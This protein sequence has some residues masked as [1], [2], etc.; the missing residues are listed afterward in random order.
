[1][2]LFSARS[3]SYRSWAGRRGRILR[4]FS[5]ASVNLHSLKIRCVQI[6]ARPKLCCFPF[7]LCFLFCCLLVFGGPGGGFGGFPVGSKSSGKA[8]TATTKKKATKTNTKTTQNKKQTKMTKHHCLAWTLP[9][10]SLKRCSHF[11]KSPPPQ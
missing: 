7:L 4:A 9:D 3:H 1:M 10:H 5:V 6:R 2:A 11:T 8:T